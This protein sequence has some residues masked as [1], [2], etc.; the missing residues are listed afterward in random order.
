MPAGLYFESLTGIAATPA[1]PRLAAPRAARRAAKSYSFR[2]FL[3]FPRK[4]FSSVVITRRGRRFLA[5]AGLV[6]LAGC[7]ATPPA[8]E[9]S[10]ATPAM[11]APTTP[12]ARQALVSQRATARW[13]LL[14][15]DDMDAAYGYMSAGS[16]VA[17]SLDK[18]KANFRRGAFR[19]ARVD[20]VTCDGD[21][22]LAKVLVTY[23]HPRMKG[24]TTPVTESWIIDGG[25]AWYVLGGRIN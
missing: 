25:Q 16:R 12:E 23:D 3:V 13:D 18:F 8:T 17:T 4:M 7:A 19:A 9:R 5:T 20:S 22:C 21:A 1:A 24:I 6:A 10:A 11:P 14:I 15:K 2:V